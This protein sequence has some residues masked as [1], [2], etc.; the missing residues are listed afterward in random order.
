MD[1]TFDKIDDKINDNITSDPDI[2]FKGLQFKL[3]KFDFKKDLIFQNM[4]QIKLD[5]PV[6]YW[7]IFIVIGL[8]FLLIEMA[9]LKFWK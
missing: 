4:T 6:E 8:I 5:K 9:L 2:I 1:I 3:K 7:R